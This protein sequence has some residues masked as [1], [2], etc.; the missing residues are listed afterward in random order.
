MTNS[1]SHSFRCAS[2]QSTLSSAPL[3]LKHNLVL[4]DLSTGTF[5]NGFSDFVSRGSTLVLDSHQ[6]PSFS[7]TRILNCQRQP[8]L[9][10]YRNQLPPKLPR[11][12]GKETP[13]EKN[14]ESRALKM[15]GV[16]SA[17]ETALPLQH[18]SLVHPAEICVTSQQ[19]QQE[20][21]KSLDRP[22]V[23][24]R[25]PP[26]HQMRSFAP[27]LPKQ[28]HNLLC[29]FDRLRVHVAAFDG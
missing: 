27:N 20:Q 6:L 22:Q 1:S 5:H 28:L 9:D 2:V 3:Y 25:P 11:P 15:L 13:C 29:H 26:P 21:N 24:I 14:P 19:Q 4:W 17:P 12:E 10:D 7:I 16:E 18:S 23:S 8:H